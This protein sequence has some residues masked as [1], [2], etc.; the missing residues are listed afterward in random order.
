MKTNYTAFPSEKMQGVYNIAGKNGR[1][2]ARD[3]IR[4]LHSERGV[5]FIYYRNQKVP[6]IFNN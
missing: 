6:V 5:F 4:T 1:F 3:V 2:V